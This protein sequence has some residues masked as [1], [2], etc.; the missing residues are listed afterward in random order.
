MLF[1]SIQS[2]K[3]AKYYLSIMYIAIGWQILEATD[4]MISR[5]QLSE[6][7]FLW[8][9][10]LLVLGLVFLITY[11]YTNS[12]KKAQILIVD[13]HAMVRSG[14]RNLIAQNSKNNSIDEA[15]NGLEALKLMEKNNY[16]MVFTDINMPVMSGISLCKNIKEANDKTKVVAF[17]MKDDTHTVRQ[18][19]DAGASGYLLKSCAVQEL[20]AAIQTINSGGNHFSSALQPI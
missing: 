1:Q 16:N 7:T 18:M 9:T 2:S 14:L 8:T 15:S 12:N 4:V 13:D 20:Q 3:L 19:V 5:F 10:I 11:T 6:S 17:T